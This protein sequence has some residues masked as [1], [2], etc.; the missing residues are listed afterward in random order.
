MK[1]SGLL[2]RAIE[3][4]LSAVVA[5]PKQSVVRGGVVV[6][7]DRERPGSGVATAKRALLGPACQASRRRSPE[8]RGPHRNCTL[9]ARRKL[10]SRCRPPRR[11]VRPVQAGRGIQRRVATDAGNVVPYDAV[12]LSIGAERSVDDAGEIGSGD[13]APIP[14]GVQRTRS[15]CVDF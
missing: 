10:G 3:S 1:D 7:F 2:A 8:A 9:I 5:G 6:D 13:R 15:A 14:A 11:S 12:P 4:A